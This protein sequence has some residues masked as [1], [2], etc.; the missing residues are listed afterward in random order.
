MRSS[1]PPGGGRRR[2][3]WFIGLWGGSV[4][5]L[6]VAAGLLKLVFNAIL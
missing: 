6:A 1:P 2:W 4:A 5:A 3:A